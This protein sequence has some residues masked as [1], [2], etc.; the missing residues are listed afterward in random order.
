MSDLSATTGLDKRILF[1]VSAPVSHLPSRTRRLTAGAPKIAARRG[2]AEKGADWRVPE[3]LAKTRGPF[4]SSIATL[5]RRLIDERLAR[6]DGQGGATR[7]LGVIL[8]AAD[9]K[10][11]ILRNP[12]T[13]RAGDHPS[14]AT[15][16]RIAKTSL[17]VTKRVR[18]ALEAEGYL[19]FTKNKRERDAAGNWKSLAPSMRRLSWDRFFLGVPPSIRG[20]FEGWI[21]TAEAREAKR[22][23][24][25][26]EREAAERKA[27]L[28]AALRAGAQKR[29]PL[30]QQEAEPL[31]ER[32]A[33]IV[34]MDA[35]H[36]EHPEWNGKQIAEELRRRARAGPP[37]S[38]PAEPP[39]SA[40]APSK[41]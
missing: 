38:G 11:G 19:Y 40:G 31:N 29:R 16:T 28:D 27:Y 33:R 41:S 26:L 7:V 2:W 13:G 24:A 25:R 4:W 39:T 36:A 18:R 9:R 3:V 12:L 35:I 30:A 22:E 32:E 1:S 8:R 10:T 34:L 37:P 6:L 21:A 20:L 23:A 15:I 17:S 14:I 5:C